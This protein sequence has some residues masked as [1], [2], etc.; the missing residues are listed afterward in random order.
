MRLRGLLHEYNDLAKPGNEGFLRLILAAKTVTER[1]E[2]EGGVVDE[3]AEH[4]VIDS[5]SYW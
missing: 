1:V 2:N 3:D 5:L 4:P